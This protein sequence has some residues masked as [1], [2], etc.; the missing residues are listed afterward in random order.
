MKSLLLISICLAISSA[1]YAR[2]VVELFD[3][4]G[5]P[6]GHIF[7][8]DHCLQAMNQCKAQLARL[9]LPGAKCEI[10]LNIPKDKINKSEIQD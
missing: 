9:N 5:D 10:T 8:N 6:V 2:C 1:C 7:Q 4:K 3:S